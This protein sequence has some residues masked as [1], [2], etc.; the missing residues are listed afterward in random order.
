MWITFFQSYEIF[1]FRMEKEIQFNLG[2]I[3]LK[4]QILIM[5]LALHARFSVYISVTF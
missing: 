5:A 2:S 4:K 1:W 3:S